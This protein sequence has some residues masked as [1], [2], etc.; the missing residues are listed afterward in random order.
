MALTL[1]ERWLVHY[2]PIHHGVTPMGIAG[3]VRLRQGRGWCQPGGVT[4]LFVGDTAA[5]I[6]L[7]HPIG[8]A[9]PEAVSI[10]PRADIEL[11]AGTHFF[12]AVPYGPGGVAAVIDPAN[13]QIARVVYDENGA[14]LPGPAAPRHLVAVAIAGGKF[15]L[16]WSYMPAPT[17]SQVA[18]FRIYS[19]GGGGTVD[20]Q[21]PIGTRAARLSLEGEGEYAWTTPTGYD[22]GETILFAVRAL[23]M[24]DVEE[25][26]TVQAAAVA[27]DAAPEAAEIDAVVLGE[28][29]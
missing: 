7:T 17:R 18:S 5:A 4:L 10:A 8:V 25:A 23:G 28:D 14:T 15:K 12:Q 19:D 16:Q 11:A 6:D 27:D 2:D 1:F 3:G 26:N 24:N 9:G 22:D 20:Y 13:R 29:E 21:T